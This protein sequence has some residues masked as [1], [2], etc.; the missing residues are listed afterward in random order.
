MIKDLSLF[1]VKASP[2]PLDLRLARAWGP[3]LTTTIDGGDA[4]RRGCLEV[5]VQDAY[6]M[7][8]QGRYCQYVSRLITVDLAI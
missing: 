8:K 3:P 6:S 7:Y 1:L 4:R 2:G 5:T